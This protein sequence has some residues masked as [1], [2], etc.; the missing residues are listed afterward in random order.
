MFTGIVEETG[1]VETFSRA[2][3]AWSLRLRAGRVLEGVAAGDS[4]AVNGCCL[5]AVDLG[6][7]TVAFDVLEETRRLT[8][9]GALAPGDPVNLERSLRADGR[10]GGHFVTG[11]IDGLGLVEAFEPRGADHWLGIRGP[12]GCGRLLVH[13]GSIAIDGISLTVAEISGDTFAVW[14]IPHT[15]AVTNLR[16]RRAGDAVN[17]EFDMLGKYVE[18]LLRAQGS[19]R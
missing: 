12:D 10:L 2:G 4:L 13:K 14:L 7:G 16:N 6:G 17:L 9:F 3:G 19:V 11:H 18:K 8:N 5:T 15:I 1:T